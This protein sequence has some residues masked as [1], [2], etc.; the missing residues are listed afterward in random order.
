MWKR[1]LLLGS[2]SVLLALS[3]AAQMLGNLNDY[4]SLGVS[5]HYQVPDGTTNEGVQVDWKAQAQGPPKVTGT[6]QSSNHQSITSD[7]PPTVIAPVFNQAR[8]FTALFHFTSPGEP[9]KKIDNEHLMLTVSHSSLQLQVQL[10]VRRADP[11]AWRAATTLWNN[12]RALMPPPG[13]ELVH[14]L[15]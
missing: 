14:E 5:M 8:N 9:P 3:S 12:L 2:L 13:R 15:H 7:L 6:V 4:P 1:L 10:T 11:A